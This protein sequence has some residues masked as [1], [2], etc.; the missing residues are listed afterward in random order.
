MAK[1]LNVIPWPT[2]VPVLSGSI[3][4][5]LGVTRTEGSTF[6][7]DLDKLTLCD[8]VREPP[9][10]KPYLVRLDDLAPQTLEEKLAKEGFRPAPLREYLSLRKSIETDRTDLKSRSLVYVGEF[11]EVFPDTN[12]KHVMAFIQDRS[13]Y[14]GILSGIASGAFVSA[15]RMDYDYNY[16]RYAVVISTDEEPHS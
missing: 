12:W 6:F 7:K 8:T 2:A 1:T 4:E 16:D 13:D 10:F 5:L 9:H 11:I 15:S 3:E 14:R